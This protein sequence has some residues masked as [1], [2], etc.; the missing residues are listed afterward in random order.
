MGTKD[1][2]VDQ[3]IAQAAEFARPILEHIRAIVHR[4]CPEVRETI[5]WGF[6]HF[7]YKGI[8]CSMA[9][10]RRHC[11]FGFWKATLL[12]DPE[13]ILSATGAEAMG[14]LGR[15]TGLK[16][17]PADKVMICY[18]QEAARRNEEGVGADRRKRPA[19]K[20]LEVPPDLAAALGKN[21]KARETFEH[22]S[23]SHRREYVEWIT[24]AKR[25]ETRVRRLATAIDW[26]AQGKSR[27][28]K[29]EKR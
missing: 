29:Y 2:G 1:A 7:D 15:I 26:L 10:F 19:A 14:R 4:A 22:F 13:R 11:A 3:Y 21:K 24:A 28:W 23:P 25:P 20:P 16:D 6:P 5:R 9:A 8:L 12:K 17:L 27:N 18:I